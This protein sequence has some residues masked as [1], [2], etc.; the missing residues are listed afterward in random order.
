M[1]SKFF[2]VFSLIYLK[3]VVSIYFEKLVI[4][5]SNHMFLYLMLPQLCKEWFAQLYFYINLI[6]S[7]ECEPILMSTSSVSVVKYMISKSPLT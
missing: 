5:C 3:V 6:K 4:L 7:W 1:I 2:R